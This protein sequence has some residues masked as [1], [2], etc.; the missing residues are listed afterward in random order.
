MTLDTAQYGADEDGREGSKEGSLHAA[1]EEGNIDIVKSFLERGVYVDGRNEN[2]QTPLDR[3][4]RAGHV[5]VVRLLVERCAH[6]ESRDWRGWT[7]HSASR[8][9]HLLVN[10]GADLNARQ[11]HHWT[12]IHFSAE[13]GHYKVV[14]LLLER[15]ADV[16]ALNDECETPYQLSPQSGYREIADLLRQH[17]ASRARFEDI[18]LRSN[19]MS[20]QHFD[21]S[22]QR[23]HMFHSLKRSLLPV[24]G[25]GSIH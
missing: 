23:H 4:T 20:D 8:S 19:A 9:G 13:N 24:S 7:P 22:L 3:A 17:G 21:F 1:A 14:K 2:N 11:R 18:L 6:V 5:S 25:F 16:H 10:H 15:G 12:P